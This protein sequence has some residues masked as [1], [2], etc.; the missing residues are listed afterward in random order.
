[1]SESGTCEQACGGG[2]YIIPQNRLGLTLQPSQRIG[3]QGIR[4][5]LTLQ[6]NYWVPALVIVAVWPLSGTTRLSRN[7]GF[8]RNAEIVT[9]AIFARST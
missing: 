9:Q 5:P 7:D 1:M 6:P 4:G 8:G 2:C 3:Q